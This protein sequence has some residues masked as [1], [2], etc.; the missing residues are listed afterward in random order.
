[1]CAHRATGHLHRG[2][3]PHLTCGG[4]KGRR[5]YARRCWSAGA[6]NKPDMAAPKPE[7]VSPHVEEQEN[8]VSRVAPPVVRALPSCDF[9]HWAD[10]KLLKC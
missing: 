6:L 4:T 1:M 7:D 5:F 3:E 10:L 9:T 2:N 8:T